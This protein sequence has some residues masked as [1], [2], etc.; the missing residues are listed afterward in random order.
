MQTIHTS[1]NVFSTITRTDK[2]IKSETTG[3]PTVTS[4]PKEALLWK[5]SRAICEGIIF[6]EEI[7]T[8]K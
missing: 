1:T 7:P 6:Y 5:I 4:T 8:G 2:Y 3:Y